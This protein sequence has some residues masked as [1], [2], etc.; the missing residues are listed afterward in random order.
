MAQPPVF[1][2]YVSKFISFT[3]MVTKLHCNEALADAAAVLRGALENKKV[4]AEKGQRHAV[5]V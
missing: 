1:F 4:T 5:C 2:R 3:S